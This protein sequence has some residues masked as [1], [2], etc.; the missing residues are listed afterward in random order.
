MLTA[1]HPRAALYAQ[2]LEEAAAARAERASAGGCA[3]CG[4]SADR[5]CSEHQADMDAAAE[6]RRAA[7]GLAG[8]EL[9][10]EAG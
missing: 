7:A 3:P 4:R 5:Y 1:A 10:P 2:A 8:R 6:Y 9:E